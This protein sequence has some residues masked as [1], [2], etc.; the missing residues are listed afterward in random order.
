[1]SYLWKYSYDVRYR[2][3]ADKSHFREKIVINRILLLLLLGS[4]SINTYASEPNEAIGYLC[5]TATGTF[6]FSLEDG[7]EPGTDSSYGM[8][9]KTC[10]LG[11]AKVQV[12]YE[13]HE[14]G[15]RG[16]CSAYPGG[17]IEELKVNSSVL[18]SRVNISTCLPSQLYEI[19]IKENNG[20]I[21]AT[22]CGSSGSKPGC[23]RDR[24]KLADV[25]ENMGGRFPYDRY[26]SRA[27][28]EGK[29][30]VLDD[31][32]VKAVVARNIE[33]IKV[34]LAKGAN[35]EAA[36][37]NKQSIIEY[38]V[39]QWNANPAVTELLVSNTKKTEVFQSQLD[40]SLHA[41]ATLAREEI[42]GILLKAGA[43]PNA[44]IEG[45]RSALSLAIDSNNL[46]PE[47]RYVGIVRLLL[48]YGANPDVQARKAGTSVLDVARE[49]GHQKVVKALEEALKK[50]RDET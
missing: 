7:S 6:R 49:R 10:D 22:Y 33:K 37:I 47:D 39:R 9:T 24:F 29:M 48:S 5:D 12:S 44:P 38:Q 42:V 50:N 28:L 43:N 4:L 20:D 23:F 26:K 16:M 36:T 18:M 8:M 13:L 25:P 17:I 31:D 21:Q 35:P 14:P 41:P 19:E 32:L 15:T 11:S 40:R 3:K 46:Y 34:L 45:R 27:V 30:S 1:L 2:P